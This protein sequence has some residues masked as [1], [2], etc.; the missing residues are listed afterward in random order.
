MEGRQMNPWEHPYFYEDDPEQKL[1]CDCYGC[2]TMRRM[3]QYKN[4]DNSNGQRATNTLSDR[5]TKKADPTA[6]P[7]KPSKIYG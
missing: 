2:A 7:Y 6:R 1:D 4:R 5:R 3:C